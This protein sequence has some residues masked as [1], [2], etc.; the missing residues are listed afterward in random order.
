MC[1]KL[2]EDGEKIIQN[3]F[4]NLN[5]IYNTLLHYFAMTVVLKPKET[6]V[7]NK[8]IQI[9]FKDAAFHFSP[10]FTDQDIV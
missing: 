7:C 10:W 3:V 1:Q 9:I 2:E 5:K 6:L 8:T 4:K